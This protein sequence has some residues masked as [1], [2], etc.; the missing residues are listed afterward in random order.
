[1]APAR[2]SQLRPV[3]RR[4]CAYILCSPL[5]DSV[6][7]ASIKEKAAALNLAEKLCVRPQGEPLNAPD[8]SVFMVVVGSTHVSPKKTVAAIFLSFCWTCSH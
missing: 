1:M 7:M 4:S 3:R 6:R 2:C 8:R 5:N